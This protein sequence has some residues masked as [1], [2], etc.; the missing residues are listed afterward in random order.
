M[1]EYYFFENEP[2]A[3]ITKIF[4]RSKRE[5][6]ITYNKM[7]DSS[8]KFINNQRAMGTMAITIVQKYDYIHYNFGKWSYA[9]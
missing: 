9:L 7:T 6:L 1:K 3:E 8:Y 5:A 2:S 4:A